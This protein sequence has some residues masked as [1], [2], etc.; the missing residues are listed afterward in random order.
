[1][2]TFRQA[3][4]QIAR[5]GREERN[6]MDCDRRADLDS[7]TVVTAATK[8]VMDFGALRSTDNF[9]NTKSDEME[10]G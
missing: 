10:N 5:I 4:G 6:Y 2:H 8:T 1:M 9:V 3:D 7:L